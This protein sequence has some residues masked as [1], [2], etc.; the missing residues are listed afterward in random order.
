MLISH[1]DLWG[2]G[3]TDTP[4]GVPH[5][6]KLLGNQILFAA[7]SSSLSWTGGQSG[8]FSIIAFS[9]GSGIAMSFAAYYPYLINS[10]ILLAPVGILPYLPKE[11]EIPFFR[12]PRVVSFIPSSYLRSMV[13]NIL[14]V[15]LK[16][17]P[18]E[19]LK[20]KTVGENATLDIPAIVQ[21]QFDHHKGFIHSFTNTIAHGPLM[22]Q[23]S[24]WK[25]VCSIIRGIP[26]GSVR[27]N[28]DSRLLNSKL[29][30]IFG[31]S[32]ELVTEKDNTAELSEMLG[33][34]QHFE[35]KVVPGGH[36][37]PVPSSN[38]VVKHVCEFWGLPA[39]SQ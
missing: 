28:E 10:I 37:F 17:T 31:D 35:Y 38:A 39:S 21:W 13:G 23:H 24:D 8:G 12:Y 1:P 14:G 33:G 19:N 32:D 27:S 16:G 15:D 25:K 5:D 4:L 29:F 20:T 7:G 9:L 30:V 6:A 36:G 26:T 11:Y 22:Y 18:A 2:R 3:Y 34:S